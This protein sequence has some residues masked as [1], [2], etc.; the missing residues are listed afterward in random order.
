M[1]FGF[2]FIGFVI[3]CNPL[4]SVYTFPISAVFMLMGLFQLGR[5]NKGFMLS[6]N[7]LLIW[8]IPA[9]AQFVFEILSQRGIVSQ[10]VTT[11]KTALRIAGIGFEMLFILFLLT[12]IEMIAKET[13]LPKLVSKASFRRYIA[14]GYYALVFIAVSSLIPIE[15]EKLLGTILYFF[16]FIFRAMIALLIWSCYMYICLEGDEDMPITPLRFKWMEKLR[17]FYNGVIFKGNGKRNQSKG[18]KKNGKK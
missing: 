13:G 3:F 5:Y 11:A 9:V 12:G 17:N 16:G 18:E 4:F 8:L 15:A 10:T 6:R 14:I 2:L 7:T 1:G